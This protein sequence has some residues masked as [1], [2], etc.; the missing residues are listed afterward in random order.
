MKRV[1]T[2]DVAHEDLQ[3]GDLISPWG[4]VV[5]VLPPAN[6]TSWVT[7]VLRDDDGQREALQPHIGHPADVWSVEREVSIDLVEEIRKVLNAVYAS[8]TSV[9][10]PGDSLRFFSGAHRLVHRLRELGVIDDA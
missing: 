3:P 5:E 7:A 1:Q 2:I 9:A 8:P 6:S 4:T 10:P